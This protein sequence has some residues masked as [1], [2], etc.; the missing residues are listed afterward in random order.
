VIGVSRYHRL[1]FLV[2]HVARVPLACEE[3]QNKGVTGRYLAIQ[4]TCRAAKA[5]YRKTKSRTRLPLDASP[6]ISTP[7]F[8][9]KGF[10]SPSEPV[11][12]RLQ[13]S[14]AIVDK[15]LSMRCANKQHTG[16]ERLLHAVLL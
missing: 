11:L 12:R 3:S 14:N 2:V 15:R 16:V 13:I 5:R 9:R 7:K 10:Q 8:S 1:G 6:M 4:L